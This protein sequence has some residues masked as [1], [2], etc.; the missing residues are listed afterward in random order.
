MR[1]QTLQEQLQ[2]K[3]VV[4]QMITHPGDRSR[5]LSIPVG[6]LLSYKLTH[7][8]APAGFHWSILNRTLWFRQVPFPG[9][10]DPT[11]G[12]GKICDANAQR[13]TRVPGEF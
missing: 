7:R 2:C 1:G 6:P 3:I 10:P 8:R 5:D 9:L 11:A 13:D 4:L 12:S